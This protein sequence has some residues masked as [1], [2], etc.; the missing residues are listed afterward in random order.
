MADFVP[1]NHQWPHTENANRGVSSLVMKYRPEELEEMFLQTPA[2][3]T[4]KLDG[5]NVAKDDTGQLYSRR[6]KIGAEESH[7]QKTPLTSVRSADISKFRASLCLAGG[8]ED[9]SLSL[10]LVYG[11]L[12]CNPQYYDYQQRGLSGQW[13][14]FGSCLLVRSDLLDEVLESLINRQFAAIK[15]NGDTIQILPCE[16]LFEVALASGLQVSPV[17]ASGKPLAQIVQ[18]NKNV[19]KKG[20]IEGLILT[21]FSRKFGYN[22]LKWK[23]KYS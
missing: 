12:M 3:A 17:V 11:E 16:A 5:T 8:L 22:S 10:V 14:I 21:I 4:E 7:F 23:G 19:M 2:F 15:L 6:L 13:R 18:E 1:N 9:D 20:Q